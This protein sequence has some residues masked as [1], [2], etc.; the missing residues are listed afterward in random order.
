[1]HPWASDRVRTHGLARANL[2]DKHGK[3]LG[4]HEQSGR[5]MVLLDGS[6]EAIRV[7]PHNLLCRMMEEED[8]CTAD[9]ED[10]GEEPTWCHA[11]NEIVVQW[12]TGRGTWAQP[13][14]STLQDLAAEVVATHAEE[15]AL[16]MADLPDPVVA[17]CDRARRSATLVVTCPHDDTLWMEVEW[18]LEVAGVD[19]IDNGWRFEQSRTHGARWLTR[20]EWESEG[21]RA[22]GELYP[23]YSVLQRLSQLLS[24]R[25]LRHAPYMSPDRSFKDQGWR[26]VA[27][28]PLCLVPVK[29]DC[30]GYH[31]S[32][33]LRIGLPV[34][35]G[36]RMDEPCVADSELTSCTLR[37]TLKKVCF[38][39]DICTGHWEY[40][41]EWLAFEKNRQSAAGSSDDE[42]VYAEK[43]TIHQC[44][45]STAVWLARFLSQNGRDDILVRTDFDD[46]DGSFLGPFLPEATN[47]CIVDDEC[48]DTYMELDLEPSGE[49]DSGAEQSDAAD[50]DTSNDDY[51]ME[52]LMRE[53]IHSL[54][55]ERGWM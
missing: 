13:R 5:F 4:W 53:E 8:G 50:S 29:D 17:L 38:P 41:A 32:G 27:E 37:R 40:N 52:E 44:I 39:T 6:H 12:H 14:S 18:V 45:E 7:K 11:A 49:Q 55:I 2:N 25:R 9:S 31:A 3:C 30:V 36:G 51:D 26:V 54:A 33:K 1:M 10:E 19:G 21:S 22:L 24:R 20:V 35:Y 15:Y 34:L 23:Y 43:Q 16:Q 28:P 47:P 46:G 48:G 42:T